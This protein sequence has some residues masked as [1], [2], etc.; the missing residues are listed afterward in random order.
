MLDAMLLISS[1]NN[2]GNNTKNNDRNHVIP[3]CWRSIAE[4]SAIGGANIA[5]KVI[6]AHVTITIPLNR[7]AAAFNA[8]LS[9]SRSRININLARN[10]SF[11]GPHIINVI[12]ESITVTNSHASFST[13]TPKYFAVNA[14]VTSD[15]NI[16]KT[17][18]RNNTDVVRLTLTDDIL[19]QGFEHL[20][21]SI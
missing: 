17:R 11:I 12:D 6:I 9:L 5:N 1:I 4:K 10:V 2:V 19:Y 13:D 20:H 14:T 3:S 15:I 18:R 21:Y 7:A 16:L 8:R